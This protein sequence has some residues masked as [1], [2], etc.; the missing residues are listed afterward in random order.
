MAACFHNGCSKKTVDWLAYCSE[1]NALHQSDPWDQKCTDDDCS[2]V[3]VEWKPFCAEH[4]R[5]NVN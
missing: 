2:N 4:D 3:S 5:F 1:H